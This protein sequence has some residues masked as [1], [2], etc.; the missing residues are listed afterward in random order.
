[1]AGKIANQ[2]RVA[3]GQLARQRELLGHVDVDVL[4][5]FRESAV[6]R[7]NGH[8]AQHEHRRSALAPRRIAER[9]EQALDQ[10]KAAASGM[11]YD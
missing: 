9:L 5:R 3:P 8:V 6:E 11:R 10:G 1:V 7:P 2:A 4:A